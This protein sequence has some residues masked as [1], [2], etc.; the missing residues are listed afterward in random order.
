MKEKIWR[1]YEI[2]DEETG[3][4]MNSKNYDK[5][6]YITIKTE[7]S[8]TDEKYYKIETTRRIVRHNGQKKLFN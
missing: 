6:N 5:K 2:I 1:I 3:E 8:I 4:L 7:K